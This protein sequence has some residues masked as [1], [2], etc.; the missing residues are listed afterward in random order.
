[1]LKKKNRLSASCF[2]AKYSEHK[3]NRLFSVKTKPNGL[4]F[5]R[6]GIVITKTTEKR[7]AARNRLRRTIYRL[8]REKKFDLVIAQD[9][10]IFVH[11]EALHASKNSLGFALSELLA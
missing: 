1:M 9:V 6:F 10:I 8:L 3:R 11:S 7:A 2:K 5:S 4:A